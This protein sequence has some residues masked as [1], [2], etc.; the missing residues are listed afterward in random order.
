MGGKDKDFW[1]KGSHPDK[2]AEDEKDSHPGKGDAHG[3][4]G[5]HWEKDS[6]PDE[7]E[8]DSHS[9]AG[10]AKGKSWG[11][12]PQPDEDGVASQQGDH[13]SALEGEG[14]AHPVRHTDQFW[15]LDPAV[16]PKPGTLLEPREMTFTD[17]GG[18]GLISRAGLDRIDGHPVT[19][20]W[21]GDI[22]TVKIAGQG[23][24]T[25]KGVT[26]YAKGMAPVFTPTDGTV[27]Q[28]AEFVSSSYVMT[29]GCVELADLEPAC[30][31]PGTMIDTESGPRPVERIARGDR[32]LT[33]DD[34]PLPVAWIGRRTV[35]ARGR[36]APVL[37]GAGVLGNRRPLLVSPAHRV[38]LRGWAAQLFAGQDEVLV[39]ARHL[40]DG[41]R[42]RIR[43]GGMV[44]YLHLGFDRHA[45]IRSEG[46]WSESHF[47]G[48]A[49][50]AEGA[51]LFPGR[52]RPPR[53]V[54][55]EVGR[56]E[57]RLLARAVCRQARPA[58]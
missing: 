36:L 35:P 37:I 42:V 38:L 28:D 40:V 7:D 12:K 57:A 50:R 14:D 32:I 11:Q 34:G 24:V 52:I 16:P 8:E 5:K 31:T 47:A 53:L 41:R 19:H 26:I 55:T 15:V 54:R 49:G 46:A 23:L 58:L 48:L 2:D 10:W 29:N 39:A 56:A 45:L 20:V 18:D 9:G 44:T 30:F 43:P 13:D 27:L 17:Q 4:K 21:N 25:V 22:V 1:V 3:A 6:H 33:L 51:A